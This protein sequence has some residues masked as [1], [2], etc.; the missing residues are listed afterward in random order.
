MREIKGMRSREG[1]VSEGAMD[2]VSKKVEKQGNLLETEL[3]FSGPDLQERDN[4][5]VV[6]FTP[7]KQNKIK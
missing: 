5:L 2:G 7:T 4:C 6:V 3:K 1:E